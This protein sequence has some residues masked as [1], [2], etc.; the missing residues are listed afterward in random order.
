MS[1]QVG[2]AFVD[3]QTRKPMNDIFDETYFK[4]NLFPTEMNLNQNGAVNSIG[5]NLSIIDCANFP[6]VE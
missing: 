5:K 1:Y 6:L 2:Y 3:K 4:I